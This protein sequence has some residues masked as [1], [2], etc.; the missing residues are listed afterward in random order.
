MEVY[1]VSW[2]LFRQL[3]QGSRT[4][5]QACPWL[6]AMLRRNKRW[7]SIQYLPRKSNVRRQ[8]AIPVSTPFPCADSLAWGRSRQRPHSVHRLRPGD[9]DVVAAIG[10]SLVA[11]SGALE[12][13]ALGAIV[14]YRG[15]S[16]C[17]GGDSTWREFLTL[18]N[19]LKEYNPGLRGYA[20]G[21]GEWLARNARL[22]VAF[23]VTSDEVAYKKAKILVARMRASPDIDME[24]DWKMVTVFIGANDLCSAS[25]LSPV[26]WSPAAHARKLARALDYFYDHLPRTIVNLIP[27]L[28]VSVSVRVVR[29][30]MCRLMHSLFCT[31]FHRGGGELADLVHMARLYQKAEVALVES[32]RYDGREDF[33]VVVQPFMRLFNAP[34]APRQPLPRC[35]RIIS[36]GYKSRRSAGGRTVRPGE[37]PSEPAKPLLHSS[38]QGTHNPD[39]M[40]V[41]SRAGLSD[42]VTRHSLQ[43]SPLYRPSLGIWRECISV[44]IGQ[45]G[46]QIGNACWELYCLEHGIQ[47]DGQMPTDKTL[48]GGDDSFNTFF[49][50]TGAGKHVPRAVFVDLEPTVVD[51]VRTGTYRQ[52]FH[53]EQL[54]T[55]KED[56]ANNYARGHYTIGKEI[57]DVVLDRIRKLADQCTGLQLKVF[58]TNRSCS[59]YDAKQR[60][61]S[62]S[63]VTS[64]SKYITAVF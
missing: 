54:I 45:A 10:D 53:P 51:E 1:L 41:D 62:S 28:D 30:L 15:V 40:L 25:C 7:Q 3:T 43:T 8:R 47:P 16:W 61:V 58:V 14:E 33:T 2:E 37:L 36:G 50:E 18:P 52:L 29:P 23:P 6:G 44:H 57:V 55:G 26:A 4:K 24:R 19:I 17:A 48:G 31:C 5:A 21:T 9:I 32:G 38:S 34:P 63:E 27:V 42:D 49:S 46:V 11:G 22:N 39:K 35:T 56:A 59:V 20:T 60:K 64:E 13:F 12:E